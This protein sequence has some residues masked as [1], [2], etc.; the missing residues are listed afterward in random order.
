MIKPET[1]QILA[2]IALKTAAFMTI[3]VLCFIVG[4]LFVK[5][6][7]ALSWSFLFENPHD[8]GRSG[9]IFSAILGTF[10]LALLSLMISTPLGVGTA[11]FLTEY[12]QESIITKIIRFGADCLS[13][14]PSIIFGLFG[15]V[16]FVIKMN[17]GWCIL[18]GA[19]TMSFMILPTIIRTAEEAIKTVPDDL[20]EASLS[21]GA[22]K[23]QTIT[24]VVLPEAVPGIMTGVVL[25]IGRTVGETAVV[26][27]TAGSALATPK[28]VFDS[29]RTMAVH[30]Y[31]IAREGIST[32]NAYGTALLIV[33]AILMINLTAYFL[34]NKLMT[35]KR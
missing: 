2:E 21:L 31:I 22:T 28:S 17:L 18:S 8:M 15:F 3:L 29:T 12:T 23:W 30:F 11:I 25:G 9:G 20:R 27:F 6:L 32:Q 33:T 10:L 19:L 26:I 1:E 16:L 35:N 5:G 14:I 13:G 24:K 7:P 4:F 34:M